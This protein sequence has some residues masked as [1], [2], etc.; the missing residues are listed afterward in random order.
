MKTFFAFW[1][2]GWF[3]WG[4]IAGAAIAVGGSLLTKP[5][6]PGAAQ[7]TPIDVQAEQ[8]KA[9]Q[10]NLDNQ[11]SIEQLLGRGNAFNQQQ[12]ISLQEQ[13]MPGYTQLAGAL[14]NRATTLAEHPYDVP[15]EVQDN[16]TRL[17]AERGIS[18]GTRGQ[19]NDFS[20]LRDLGVNQL[21]YGQQALGQAQQISG[22]LAAIAPKVNP[23]SPLS[24]YLTP[25][26]AISSQTNNN[27]QQQAIAQGGLNT[28]AA[29]TN[30]GNADLWG[31]LSKIAG[32]Y[33]GGSGGGSGAA[34]GAGSGLF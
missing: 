32:L 18:A 20:L 23:M 30:A 12:A 21:Q 17:A 29:A 16:L 6:A 31:S 10:G 15:Q 7:Y 26:Q 34:A 19:F 5:K 9:I 3:T 13:A 4:A 1:L 33:L 28:N 14:T 24:F 2:G 25:Q 11:S 22:V 8:K 27:T